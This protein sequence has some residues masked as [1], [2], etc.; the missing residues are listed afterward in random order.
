VDAL[1]DGSATVF[2]VRPSNEFAMSHIPGAVNVSAKPGVPISVYV[3]DAREIERAVA[4]NKA[5]PVILYCNGPHC[6]K[7]KRLAEELLAAGFTRVQRYQAGIPVW[8]AAGHVTEMEASAA[9]RVRDLDQTAVFID[10]RGADAFRQGSVP[11]AK[12]IPRSLVTEEKDTGEVRKAKDDGR[13]PMEDHNTRIIVFGASAGEARA[14]A[15]AIARE[16]F[17]NVSFFAGSPSEL[18]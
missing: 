6:G 5:A 7:S 14:V 1:R 9:K 2:D 4:G 17:H 8:R 18:R 11:G 10:A 16:A 15:A 12:S 3:S 13:L